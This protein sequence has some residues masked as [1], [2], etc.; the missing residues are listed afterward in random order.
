MNRRWNTTSHEAP[1]CAAGK[2]ADA[3]RQVTH[4]SHEAK[5]MKSLVE[6]AVEDGAHAVKRAMKSARR[7]AEDAK[8]TVTYEIRRRPL[9]AVGT[10]LG[11]GVVLGIAATFLA[12][13]SHRQA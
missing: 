2:A 12:R 1:S 7:R 6:D 4:L 8:D 10:A 5:L 9:R 13:R 3:V 11:F